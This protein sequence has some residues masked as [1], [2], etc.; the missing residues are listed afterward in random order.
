MFL[1][2][3]QTF[4]R[5]SDSGL[6]VLLAFIAMFITLLVKVFALN[7]IKALSDQIPC[8]VQSGRSFVGGIR[9]S[10]VARPRNEGGPGAKI[11]GVINYS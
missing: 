11:F 2:T 1:F 7:S 5:L 4:F 9:D 10:G 6:N 3:W 8:T